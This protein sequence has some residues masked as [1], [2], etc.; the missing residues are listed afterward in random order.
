[1]QKAKRR[2]TS[3]S[4]PNF[5]TTSNRSVRVAPI[6][7]NA[8]TRARLLLVDNYCVL[9]MQNGNTKAINDLLLCGYTE[10]VNQLKNMEDVDEDTS[11]FINNDVPQLL[12]SA[13]RWMS[14]KIGNGSLQAKIK[15]FQQAVKEG[16]TDTVDQVLADRKN[17]ALYRDAEGST[18]LHDAIENRQYQ[19]ALTLMQKY[20]SMA[21][22]KDV[23]SVLAEGTSGL[24][25]A[26]CLA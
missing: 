18:S 20:P 6:E 19:I 10:I 17:V 1:M 11:D 12:V 22:V 23:V 4:R 5:K 7:F 16:H 13:V 25:I 14:T 26:V 15:E 2:A 9:L 24:L 8:S 21:N 3:P